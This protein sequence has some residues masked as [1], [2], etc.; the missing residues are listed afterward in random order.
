[1]STKTLFFRSFLKPPVIATGGFC[2]WALL[3]PF[4]AWSAPLCPTGVAPKGAGLIADVMATGRFIAYQPTGLRFYDG[5]AA[6]VDE[7]SIEADLK[8]LRPRFDGLMTYSAL[9]GAERIPDVAA[10]LGYRAVIMGIW[11]IT[12]PRERANVV[13]AAFRQPIVAGV[14]VGNE[15]LLAKRGTVAEAVKAMTQLRAQAPGLAVATTEPFDM[16]LKPQTAPILARTDVLLANVHPIFEPWFKAAP[17][18]NAAEF[19]VN[20]A[21][22]LS[23][24]YCGP[25]LVK[26]TGVPTAP[27]ELGFTLE[28][29]ASFYRELQK[30]FP[31]SSVRAFAYFSAFDA[32]WRAYDE[33]VAPGAHPEEAHFGLYDD[34]RKPKT[35]VDV[36][37]VLPVTR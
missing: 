20:V 29:Q 13:A 35:V 30:Q 32:L 22:L 7:T 11:D 23:D 25:V 6:P 27:A 14:S 36:I 4:A 26:E 2:L 9:N 31:P 34:K 21:K 5:K 24:A 18:A 33:Q 8:I 10:Q 37:S 17:D 16:W 3:G 15:T 19:V 1:M 28:R 12:N